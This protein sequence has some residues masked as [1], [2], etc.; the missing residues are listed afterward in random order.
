MGVIACVF[1]LLVL[2]AWV[3]RGNLLVGI[4]KV[5]VVN[6]PPSHVDA[7]VVLG[8]GEQ[9]RPFRA[10]ELYRAGL[11]PQILLIKNEERPTDHMSITIGSNE[12]NRRVLLANGVP[13]SAITIVGENNVHNTY[14]ESI[15]LRDWLQSHRLT[16]ILIPTDLFHT[17]RT[18][19]IFR[20]AV[21]PA[22]TKV[23]VMAIDNGFTSSNWWT[24][25]DGLIS[26]QT[27]LGKMIFY[28]L[29]Y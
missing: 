13:E 14:E 6:D 20:R 1:L 27:E 10:A 5:W 18:S 25:E 28:R 15:A 11:A 8:G 16:T 19:W 9:S 26:F 4:A 29:K 24:S 22:H 23:S 12:V 7:I 17:R 3:W 21:S 2:L